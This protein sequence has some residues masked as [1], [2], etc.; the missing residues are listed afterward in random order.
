MIVVA[1]FPIGTRL[2]LAFCSLTVLLLLLHFPCSAADL[3]V[4]LVLSGSEAPYQNFLQS[5]RKSLPAS[6]Q[7]ST[8]EYGKPWSGSERQADLVVAVGEKA[9]AQAAP[10]ATQPVL[11]A[12]LP[13]FRYAALARDRRRGGE[14]SAI[15]VDQPWERQVGLL[16]AVLP[17]R[18]RVGVLLSAGTDWQT[19]QLRSLL[20]QR[21][22]ALVTR[23]VG[24]PDALSDDLESILSRSDVLLAVP[25]SS[26][27]NSS[28][29]RDIMLSSYRHG[30]PL[31]GLSQA[32]VNAGALCA[33]F[34]TLEQLAAQTAAAVADYARSGRL[35]GPQYPES[36]TI[37]LNQQVARSLE[38]ELPAVRAIRE[39]ID[40][41][42]HDNARNDNDPGDKAEGGGS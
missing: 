5:F 6:I 31:V 1:A 34:S 22:A 13:S 26:I 27:Y 36:Y 35:P 16:R 3:R 41:G 24:P 15:F 37:A 21:G 12:L 40:S 20:A 18:N 32:Y 42:H 39:Q 25:D 30:V 2:R 29:I 8:Q 11:A 33:V 10:R 38:I 23:M 28:N 19:E 17:Y 4:L 9:A 7:L 14:L